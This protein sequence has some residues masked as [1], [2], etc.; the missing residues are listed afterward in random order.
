MPL[1][2]GD[3]KVAITV[4]ADHVVAS[5]GTLSNS[6]DIL[7][8]TQKDRWQKA[9]KNSTTPTIIVTE[10]EARKAEKSKSKK[11]KTW[12]YEAENVRDF[13]F[14]SSRKFIWDAMAVKQSGKTVMAMSYYPKEGNPLWEQFSTR[15]VAHTLQTYS[16]YTFDYPYPVAISVH[17]KQIGME[18]P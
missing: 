7:T 5:T 6:K 9:T 11:T 3:F 13:A 17:S 8:S 12:V 4:P 2:F 1:T 16:K 10:E 18:Y 15:A 14:A